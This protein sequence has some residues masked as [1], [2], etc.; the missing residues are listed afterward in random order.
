MSY[1]IRPVFSGHETFQC[2]HLWLKKGYDFVKAG[3]AFKEEDAVVELGVGKNMVSS[4]RYWMRAFDILGEEDNLTQFA[5][6]L[7]SDTGKDPYLEDDASLWLLHYN[8]VRKGYATTYSLI[9]NEFRKERIE[10]NKDSFIKFVQNKFDSNISVNTIGTDFDVFLK[11]YVGTESSKDNEDV[12]AGILPDLRLVR[13]IQRERQL[14]LYH[15]ET[16]EKED[17]PEE[18]LLY[19]LLTDTNIGL[20]VS[21]DALEKDYNSVGSIFAINRTGLVQ[22]IENLCNRYDFLVYKDDAGIRELQFKNKPKAYEIL[23]DYYAY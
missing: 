19:A 12:V 23:N 3:K 1:A 4:I 14:T 15:I 22:K 18:V 21:L 10:F 5:H 6:W 13:V 20:S 17:L 2:R 9:F 11:L 7:F 8:L 16:S